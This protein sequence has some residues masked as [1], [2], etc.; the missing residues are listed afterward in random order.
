[1]YLVC[2]RARSCAVIVTKALRLRCTRT[3]LG[4]LAP[5]RANAHIAQRRLTG[6]LQSG[7]NAWSTG[8]SFPGEIS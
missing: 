8:A 1:V 6:Q 2:G 7:P 3:A 5:G 4:G